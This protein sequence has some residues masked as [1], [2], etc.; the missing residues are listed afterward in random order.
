MLINFN[1]GSLI[2]YTHFIW[3][4]LTPKTCVLEAIRPMLTQLT[5]VTSHNNS[6]G[7][8]KH[9]GHRNHTRHSSSQ[10][11]MSFHEVVSMDMENINQA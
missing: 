3:E 8:S 5:H 1:N 4:S 6:D 10:T 2:R 7:Q 9:G 11:L